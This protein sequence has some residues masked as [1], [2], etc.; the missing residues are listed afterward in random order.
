[1]IITRIVRACL[2]VLNGATVFG[3]LYGADAADEAVSF[4]IVLTGL[5]AALIASQVFIMQPLW[6]WTTRHGEGSPR[7]RS[8]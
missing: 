7:Q 5:I 1:M 2:L 6:R 3:L 4:L 8:Q